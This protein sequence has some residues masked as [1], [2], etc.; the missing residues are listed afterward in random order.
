MKVV[1]SATAASHLTAIYEFIARD[2]QR[3]AL[4]MID[5]LTNRSRQIA[6]FPESGQI[7]PEYNDSAIREV[8]EGPYRI[9]YRFDRDRIVVVSVIHGAQILPPQVP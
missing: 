7:V 1:W 4:R 2:S 6:R 9:I 5:R 8:I 3:Y